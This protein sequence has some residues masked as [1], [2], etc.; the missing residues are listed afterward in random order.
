[1]DK[2]EEEE[3]RE[4]VVHEKGRSTVGVFFFRGFLGFSLHLTHTF[5]HLADLYPSALSHET[6]KGKDEQPSQWVDYQYH[7]AGASHHRA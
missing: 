3:I 1:M 2:D 4:V 7:W 5:R 6:A